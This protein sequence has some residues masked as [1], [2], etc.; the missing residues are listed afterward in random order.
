M[1]R[2][3]QYRAG[4]RAVWSGWKVTT[5]PGT[6]PLPGMRLGLQNSMRGCRLTRASVHRP[7][8]VTAEGIAF[9]RV[10][11]FVAGSEPGLALFRTAVRPALRIYADACLFL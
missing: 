5:V 3:A 4:G 11:G 9:V 6:L 2:S 1:A 7:L 8:D 10:A